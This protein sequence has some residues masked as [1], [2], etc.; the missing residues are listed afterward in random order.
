MN[1]DNV[2]ALIQP[3]EFTDSLTEVLRQGA[4]KLV[5]QAVEAEFSSFLANHSHERLDDG[6][7]RVVRHGHLPERKVMTGIGAVPVRVPRSRDRK[8]CKN[9]FDPAPDGK[10]ADDGKIR[11]ASQLLPPYIRR[12]KSIEKAIPYLYLKGVSSGDFC[13]VMPVLL[14][15]EATVGF[16][17]DAV[18]RLRKQWKE[19]MEQ[20]N[21]R[22]LDSQ[23]YL[24]IWADGVYLSA[25]LEEEKQCLL[26]IIGATPE[27]KKELVGFTTGYR[28]STQSWRELLLDLKDKGLSISPKL[29]IGDGAMGFWGALDQV[30]PTTRQQRCW[31]HKTFNV[32]DKFPKSLQGKTKSEIQNIWMA[33]TKEEAL[34]AFDLFIEKYQAKYPKAAICLE[35]DREELFAFYDFPAEH[36]KHIRTTNPIESTFATVKHRTKR[37][38]GCLARETAYIMVF[39]LIKDAEKTWRRLTGKNQLPKLI[40]GVKFQNGCEI[41][42]KVELHAA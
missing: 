15:K 37:S 1:K 23:N 3:G 17:A 41:T 29:A 11:F 9:E 36:W 22:R 30:F 16:S 32:M 28:E 35:K 12:S 39:R 34:R 14:G 10:N 42:S 2:V 20:W 13:D 40:T 21:K 8:A 33:Q 7:Q 38:K 18:L 31:V 27:G 6:R 4:R 26:V 25:R 5:L 19:E 24:Y